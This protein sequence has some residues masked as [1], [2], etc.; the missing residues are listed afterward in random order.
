[1]FFFDRSVFTTGKATM[2]ERTQCRVPIDKA[3]LVPVASFMGDQA[4]MEEPIMPNEEIEATVDETMRSMRGLKLIADGEEYS[5]V[6]Q[7]AVG[8]VRFKYHVPHTPN[9]YGCD[10]SNTVSDVDVDPSFLGGYFVLF[11]PPTPGPHELEFTSVMTFG[12]RD[13]S[14]HVRYKFEVAETSAR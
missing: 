4:G 11:K 12:S 3:I 5:A 8:I 6:T 7:H 2:V 1:V 9:R 10:E 14:F 13:F